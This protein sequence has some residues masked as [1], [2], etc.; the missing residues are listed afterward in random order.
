LNTQ[1]CWFA[2]VDRCPDDAWAAAEALQVDGVAFG[3]LAVWLR[4]D[5]PIREAVL[6]D[7]RAFDP[8]GAAAWASLLLVKAHVRVLFD[9]PAV[10]RARQA[11][12]AYNPFTAVT[13][14]ARDASSFG[15]SLVARRDPASPAAVVDDP[16]RVVANPVV[17]RIGPGLVGTSPALPGPVIERYGGRPWPVDRF[18]A[19]TPDG[20]REVRH[21]S[22]R[23]TNRVAA[24]P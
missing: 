21:T 24:E 6:A 13:T 22:V 5:R 11:L 3:W 2:S 4:Q 7:A 1:R 18:P 19:T 8:G 14:L 15:G 23:A 20:P 12:L 10:Q 16:F 17:L 9:D